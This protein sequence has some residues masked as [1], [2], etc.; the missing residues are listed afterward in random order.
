M[1]LLEVQQTLFERFWKIR[2]YLGEPS[3]LFTAL[4]HVSFS[5]SSHDIP[6]CN[7]STKGAGRVLEWLVEAK[8]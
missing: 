1:H 3:D 7:A 5:S 6:V 4:E 8:K 2:S